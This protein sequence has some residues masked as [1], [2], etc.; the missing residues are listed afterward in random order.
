MATFQKLTDN[1]NSLSNAEKIALF[2]SVEDEATIE[3][4]KKLGKPFKILIYNEEDDILEGSITATPP[5]QLVVQ[6]VLINT[7]GYNTINTVSINTILSNKSNI[8]IAVTSNKTDFYIYDAENESWEIIKLDVANILANGMNSTQVA[9]VPSEGWTK[10]TSKDKAL[11][12]ALA[13]LPTNDVADNCAVTD[14][15]LNVDK[16]GPWESQV[17]GTT[18]DYSY[19]NNE[20]LQLKIYK[21][22]SYKINYNPGFSEH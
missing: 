8:R 3:D 15:T 18:Y 12:F 5:P 6:T 11:G 19:P 22:G 4:L 13:F 2:Q 17:Q 9:A 16:K 21:S 10:L 14:I 20:T 1:W 7:S